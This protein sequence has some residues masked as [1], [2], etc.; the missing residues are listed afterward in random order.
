M[1]RRKYSR[2]PLDLPAELTGTGSSLSCRIRDYCPGG[3]LLHVP[4]LAE[5]HIQS[6]TALQISFSA[7][8][9]SGAHTFRVGG[10]AARIHEQMVGIVFP[11]EVP[12]EVHAA[13]HAE[14]QAWRR[15]HGRGESGTTVAE[16]DREIS[17]RLIEGLGGVVADNLP[18]MLDANF[19][20]LGNALFEEADNATSNQK[21]SLCFETMNQFRAEAGALARQIT[22]QVMDLVGGLAAGKRIQIG[23]GTGSD[24]EELSLVDENDFE[25]W[26]LVSVTVSKAEDRHRE[27]L[28]L[29]REGLSLVLGEE[30]DDAEVPLGPAV[31]TQAFHDATKHLITD[32]DIQGIVYRT[33]SEKFVPALSGLFEAAR[34]QLEDTGVLELIEKQRA[35]R[36]ADAVKKK[37][38]EPSARG[39]SH[40]GPA[41][42]AE[43]GGGPG[44]G[45]SG[46]GG[47]GGGGPGGGGPG[48][49]GPGGGG[50]GG[51]GPGGGA[52]AFDSS[53]LHTLQSLFGLQRE[54]LG[55]PP[56][57]AGEARGGA[58][59]PTDQILGALKSLQEKHAVP[60]QP[61]RDIEEAVREELGTLA[62]EMA[63][64]ELAEAQRVPMDL[65]RH[66]FSSID[67][68]TKLPMETRGWLRQLEAPL[69]KTVLTDENFIN[70][71]QH[72]ARQ[73]V[74]NMTRLASDRT[75]AATGLDRTLQHF[76]DRIAAE[77]Q[78]NQGV[79]EE[80]LRGVKSLVERRD[81]AYERSLQ[82]IASTQQG[83]Q[84]LIEARRK[85]GRRLAAVTGD[86]S[87]A[88]ILKTLI[89]ET[90][91]DYL[92][93]LLVREGEENQD[94]EDGI[95]V[96][97]L[98]ADWLNPTDFRAGN[99][100]F[101]E[102][103]IEEIAFVKSTLE[104]GLAKASTDAY[105][106]E[107]LTGIIADILDGKED[108]IDPDHLQASPL[109]PDLLHL[110]G[111]RLIE[112]DL[113]SLSNEERRLLRRLR[114]FRTGETLILNPESES[115]QRVRL[116]WRA[117]DAS[118][119][120]FVDDRGLQACEKS[121]D[122]LVHEIQ[123]DE[124]EIVSGEE[125]TILDQSIFR[126]IQDTYGKLAHEVTHDRVT[127][128]CNR[129][130]FMLELEDAIREARRDDV[131]E[132]L[133]YVDL[134]Q[135]KVVNSD[136]GHTAGDALLQAVS[137]IIEKTAPNGSTIG[138]LGG[139]E[140]GILLRKASPKIGKLFA[141]R[142]RK[143]IADFRFEWEGKPFRP[144][145]SIGVVPI[146]YATEDVNMLMRAA[147]TTCYTAKEEGRNR[148][149]VYLGEGKT[150]S[151][152][153]QIMAWVSRIN[154]ALENNLLRL[155]LQRIA[156]LQE[157]DTHV[158][159]EVLLSVFDDEGAQVSPEELIEAAEAYG[160]MQAVDRWV[161][162]HTLKWM[163][164]NQ[165]KVAEIGGVAINLSGAS[166]G[167]EEFLDFLLGE[168]RA[169]A[170]PT[171]W[172][173]FEVTETV[174][175]GDI[176]AAADFIRE[177]RNHGCKFALDDFGSGLAS[178]AYLK[179]LP[180]DYLKI[181][182]VFIRD[183]VE[184]K[185]D[186]A[187]VKS[188]NEISHF[189]GKK[190]IAEY[191]ENEEI[192]TLLREIGI[193]YAQGWG[194]QKPVMMDEL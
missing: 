40:A 107:T 58:V 100:S 143:V 190:T 147:D 78:D 27:L 162:S 111:S 158:H 134:D 75:M 18:G 34:R 131:E 144:T 113:Q 142:L 66:V 71:R 102:T 194:V 99:P 1:E 153:S 154:L 187:M 157:G 138:R 72:P 166:V 163:A 92:V 160:R 117:E 167:D 192:L 41:H 168:L 174:T 149:K 22:D 93:S 60:L 61:D 65:V 140:F 175:V 50:P 54:V 23:P 171:D 49:G 121:A 169:S 133:C 126:M 63:G 148:V 106:Q 191:V 116:A 89:E 152:Q 81:T 94:Y 139:D 39:A 80:V 53:E 5:G 101:T 161:V 83:H 24:P 67:A 90:W 26:L 170:V 86:G 9:G 125:M 110:S 7:N 37:T 88:M 6:G 31:I 105:L 25:D 20:A 21:Q 17:A 184:S 45:G 141:E 188:I 137:E 55:T 150:P 129:K 98:L 44:G 120:V 82:R 51:G 104:A 103:H 182:G 46:G 30:L 35:Q 123:R 11:P 112:A 12:P 43:F 85:V 56:R 95:R 178:Y 52:G 68:D 176:D 32:A 64:L 28:D 79:F 165:A 33:F 173:C 4:A 189:L 114:N 108:E 76:A 127:G 19:K 38:P 57:N 77:Y 36:R 84:R 29:V 156:P 118:R 97:E 119:F 122:E 42:E 15:D 109:N 2:Q 16:V 130:Q 146:T 155:R 87:V 179:N 186:L 48:G 13:L 159:N 185:A 132:V 73:V 59:M 91:R 70:D 151:R 183:I 69:L 10:T 128:I 124:A 115:A 62:P 136:V 177:V 181:D 164:A 3:V 193:D 74:N 172:I 8:A 145:A 180:V 47:P 14:V 96:V 135:F